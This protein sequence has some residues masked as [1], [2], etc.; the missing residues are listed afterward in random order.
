[1]AT[2]HY[3]GAEQFLPEHRTITALRESVQ[4][5]RGCDL[6]ADATQAVFG[7]GKLA[8]RLIM[9]GEQ[10][11]DVEDKTG[12]P[13]TG[14]AGRLLDKALA[15]AGI[16]REEVFLTNAVKHFRFETRGASGKRR[17]H[18]SPSQ[19]QMI[20][21]R[22]WMEAELDT[23]KPEGVVVLGSVAGKALFGSDFRV[24]D[25]RGKIT[26]LPDR[27]IWSLTTIHPSAALRADNRQEM[28]DGLVADL[29]LAARTLTG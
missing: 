20:A 17:I 2:T 25:H 26:E 22:P 23:V 5:C 3:P 18:K 14:P 21:C 27:A 8:A 7:E 4:G 1:M 15:A 29:E 6:Y 24:G 19:Q 28:F 16:N 10:P 13:F 9:I 12:R 11:G